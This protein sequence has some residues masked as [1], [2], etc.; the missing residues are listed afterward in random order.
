MNMFKATLS[1][2]I[3]CNVYPKIQITVTLTLVARLLTL[4]LVNYAKLPLISVS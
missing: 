3:L 2:I 1:K 4:L